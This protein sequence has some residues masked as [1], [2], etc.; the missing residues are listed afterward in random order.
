MLYNAK[1]PQEYL[2][3]LKVDWRKENIEII[4][5]WIIEIDPEIEEGIQY[6]ML[7]YGKGV[8]NLFHLNAQKN[9]VS[10]Y[11]GDISKIE[12]GKNLLNDLDLGKGCI[13][14]KKSILLE[15]TLLKSFIQKTIEYWNNGGDTNC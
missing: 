3:L 1:T 6:K 5:A 10:L 9:Y 15:E 2:S 12:N 7:S 14:I 13:R 4:R 8:H 11:V